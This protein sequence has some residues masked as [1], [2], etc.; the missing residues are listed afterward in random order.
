MRTLPLFLGAALLFWGWQTGLWPQALFMGVILE[1]FRLTRARLRIQPKDFSRLLDLCMVL[2]LG[3]ALYLYLTPMEDNML[4]VLAR[5]LPMPLFP[6]ILAEVLSEEGRAK[7]SGIL[8]TVRRKSGLKGK[9]PVSV[10][11]SVPYSLVCLFAAGA[12]NTRDPLFY[13]VMAA[14]VAWGLYGARPSRHGRSVWLALALFC[15]VVGF[16][17]QWSVN[18]IQ[19]AVRGWVRYDPMRRSITMG[20]SGNVE[21]SDR[22]VLRVR[23]EKSLTG[24]LLLREATYNY[25]AESTWYATNSTFDAVVPLPVVQGKG[26]VDNSGSAPRNWPLAGN[27]AAGRNGL[28]IYQYIPRRRRLLALPLGAV[29]LRELAAKELE[30]SPLGAVLAYS[31]A[32]LVSYKVRSVPG[33]GL[34]SPPTVVDKITP[35][36]RD[37]LRGVVDSLNLEGL[38]NLEKARRIRDYYRNNF[39]YTLHLERNHPEM[40]ALDEFLAHSHKGHCEYFGLA[41][42]FTLRMAGIPSRYAVGYMVQE[43][44]EMEEM[45]VARGTHGH[46]W[47]LGWINGRWMNVDATP[48]VWVAMGTPKDGWMKSL[49]DLR[50]YLAFQFSQW[51]WL[52]GDT[53][54]KRIMLWAILPLLLFLGI[55]LVR[56]HSIRRSGGQ[57]RERMRE[58]PFGLVEKRLRSQGWKRE[59]SESWTAFLKRAGAGSLQGALRLYYKGRFDPR[60]RNREEERLMEN[61]VRRWLDGN[62]GQ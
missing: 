49:A 54:S 5:W 27:H 37:L 51:R 43:Y 30:M 14:F 61:E 33:G 32:G 13:P 17:G 18:A 21:L 10:K 4:L 48:P 22:I 47:A 11:I 50:Q 19:E 60:G 28:E 35:K 31:A 41:A 20:Q 8:Y 45:Y 7:F 6:L 3:L 59:P 12:A 53:R 2:V 29:E 56:R 39:T 1:V 55:R 34:D 62:D 15:L 42:V 38:D 58:G 36:S 46:A 44:S 57:A 25:F 23:A 52:E 24:P 9:S 16:A 40:S 26:E